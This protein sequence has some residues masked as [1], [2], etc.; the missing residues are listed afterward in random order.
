MKNI[1]EAQ[2]HM[3]FPVFVFNKALLQPP[4]LMGYSLRILQAIFIA[5]TSK[6]T[7]SRDK[8]VVVTVP[9][10]LGSMSEPS[11]SRDRK[12]QALLSCSN[13]RPTSFAVVIC[14]FLAWVLTSLS[15]GF[16]TWR[17]GLSTPGSSMPHGHCSP[18]GPGQGAAACPHFPHGT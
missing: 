7:E 1:S 14:P 13:S 16:R 2:D 18:Q 12:K 5:K 9:W 15:L 17:Q 8:A 3:D 10:P 6:Y 11:C 4:F